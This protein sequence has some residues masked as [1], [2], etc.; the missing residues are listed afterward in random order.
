MT[1]NQRRADSGFHNPLKAERESKGRRGLCD[2]ED[3]ESTSG[4]RGRSCHGAR[5]AKFGCIGGPSLVIIATI[6]ASRKKHKPPRSL[7]D[8]LA[9]RKKTQDDRSCACNYAFLGFCGLFGWVHLGMV[10]Q[11]LTK[12]SCHGADAVHMRC[13]NTLIRQL[14]TGSTRR[15]GIW[16]FCSV[17]R[18][19][20]NCVLCQPNVL[21]KRRRASID[22]GLY[23]DVPEQGKTRKH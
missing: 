2:R 15:A 19:S 7:W 8:L 20:T 22:C 21:D 1:K 3:C 17:S 14:C 6:K 11:C 12:N 16:P 9:T 13:N 23:Q 4:D 10:H 18:L 5:G